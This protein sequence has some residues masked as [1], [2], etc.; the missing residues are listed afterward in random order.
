MYA[1]ACINTYIYGYLLK[2]NMHDSYGH[3]CNWGCI[4]T[5]NSTCFIRT[6]YL[7]NWPI[8]TKYLC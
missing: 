2:I 8:V 7:P 4:V 6:L 5:L 3:I 1:H